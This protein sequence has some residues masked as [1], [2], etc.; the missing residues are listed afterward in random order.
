MANS[1]TMSRIVPLILFSVKPTDEH[2]EILRDTVLEGISKDVVLELN[3][4]SIS[5]VLFASL[6]YHVKTVCKQVAVIQED[7]RQL[8]KTGVELRVEDQV[9]SLRVRLPVPVGLCG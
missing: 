7:L 1:G 8:L 9:K 3:G 2:T 6:Y 4:A 5:P